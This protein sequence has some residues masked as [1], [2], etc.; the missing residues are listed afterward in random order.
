MTAYY[1]NLKKTR[2]EID[3]AIAELAS[4]KSSEPFPIGMGSTAVPDIRVSEIELLGTKWPYVPLSEF[5]TLDPELQELVDEY[6]EDGWAAELTLGML[7]AR[8]PYSI[9]TV[10]I[11]KENYEELLVHT[12]AKLKKQNANAR[13]LVKEKKAQEQI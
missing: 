3:A 11:L 10:D 13:A 9:W 8:L 1:S 7:L 2:E 5:P 12:K 6:L 4:T